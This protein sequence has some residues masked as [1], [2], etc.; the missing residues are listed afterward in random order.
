M[1]M[2]LREKAEAM[3][4]TA[5]AKKVIVVIFSRPDSKST[6]NSRIYEASKIQL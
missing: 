3:P 5:R 6:K 4:Q 1:S 2:G